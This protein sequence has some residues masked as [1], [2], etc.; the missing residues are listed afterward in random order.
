[1]KAPNKSLILI[2]V[3]TLFCCEKKVLIQENQKVSN[4]DFEGVKINNRLKF[5]DNIFGGEVQS[6]NDKNESGQYAKYIDG[7]ISP[8]KIGFWKEYYESGE[9]KKE[10]RYLIGRYVQCCLSGHC[11]RYYNYKIGKWNYYYPDGVL[12]LS[13]NYST[14]KLQIDTNCGGD[15]IKYGILD[16]DTKYY[17][18]EGKRIRKNIDELKLNYEKEYAHI[19]PG[20]YLIPIKDNDSIISFGFDN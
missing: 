14:K 18:Q 13:G 9:L 19:H 5:V 3:I 20:I 10:G 16:S 17:D 12:E 4:F 2:F 15:Y 11:M 8:Y 7:E 6:R 1:M